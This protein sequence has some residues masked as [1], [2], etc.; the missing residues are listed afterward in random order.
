MEADSKEEKPLFNNL[1]EGGVVMS[2]GMRWILGSLFLTLIIGGFSPHTRGQEESST[3]LASRVIDRDVYDE[4]KQLIG[5]VDDI[6]IRRS[7]KVKKLTV[8][9]GGFLDIGDKLVA[10]PFKSLDIKKDKVN[11]GTTEQQLENKPE[12]N[13]YTSGLRPEYY[14]RARPYAGPYYHPPPG[15]YYGPNAPPNYLREPHEW[16]YSPARFLASAVIDRRL[17]NE[18]GEEIGRVKDLVI[19]RKDNKIETIIIFSREILGKDLHIGLAYEPL[20]FSAYGLVYNVSPEELKD[21]IYP[22][23]E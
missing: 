2:R 12:F 16:T 8:E 14:Y 3:I 21:F 6:I 7:G 17:I 13:Y 20:G 4:N 5:E 23:K 11:I 19:N 9:F 18:E 22:Y 15:Y 1:R 10:L